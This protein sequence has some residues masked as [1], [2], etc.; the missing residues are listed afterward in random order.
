MLLKFLLS[1]ATE[2][3]AFATPCGEQSQKNRFI[4]QTPS[5]CHIIHS[6]HSLQEETQSIIIHRVTL[7]ETSYH[8]LICQNRCHQLLIVYLS[9]A[10]VNSLEQ[11]INFFIRHL[12]TQVCENVAELAD[13]DETGHVFIKDLEAT[14]VRVW[15]AWFSETAGTIQDSRKGFVVD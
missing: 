15:V 3:Y 9:A 12:F 8:V 7:H 14:A 13:A 11:F 1:I 4:L 2:V 5:Q 6:H 10:C